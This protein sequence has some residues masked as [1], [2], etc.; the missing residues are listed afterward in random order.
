MILRYAF[1][2]GA[3]RDTLNLFYPKLLALAKQ[4]ERPVAPG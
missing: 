3:D 4:A 1:A 2:P